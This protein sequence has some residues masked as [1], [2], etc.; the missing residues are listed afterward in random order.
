MIILRELILF[1]RGFSHPAH[2]AWSAVLACI[3]VAGSCLESANA[4][5]TG[6]DPTNP[7]TRLDIRWENDEL[8]YDQQLD[9]NNDADT[10]ILRADA[11][12]PLGKKGSSGTLAFR[13]DLPMTSTRSNVPGE[14]GEFGFGSVYLQFL[15]I[16][17]KKWG[18]LPKAGAW[19]WGYAAQ[20]A[21]ATNG[22]EKRTDI[23]VYGSKWGMKKDKDGPGGSFAV[24]VLKY[25]NG[26]AD[27]ANGFDAIS[28]FHLQPTINFAMPIGIDFIT[29]WGNFDWVYNFE[30]A[31]VNSYS[32]GDYFIPY[33]VTFGKMLSGG[34]VVLSASFAGKLLSS[35]DFVQFDER[36][37][38]RFGFFF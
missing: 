3:V 15:H 34:K 21:T 31:V 11:P 10:V 24:P 27:I 38:L 29:L 37:M 1:R 19:A 18:N 17:P 32:S 13:A 26:D 36:F 7:I 20:L 6:Q 5:N 2:V 30:D 9:N 25:Y 35:S 33:D 16:V 14:S 8:P 12:I 22:R 28:E 23:F 4:G